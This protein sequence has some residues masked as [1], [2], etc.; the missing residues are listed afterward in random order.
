MLEIQNEDSHFFWTFDKKNAPPERWETLKQLY[1]AWLKKRYGSLDKA[2]SAWEAARISGDNPSDGRM[3]LLSAWHM[4]SGGLKSAPANRKRVSDQVRFLT[5]N[6]RSFYRKAIAYFRTECGYRGLISCGNW[7]TADASILGPLER[8]CYTAGDVIDHHGYFDHG[9]K[10]DGANWS[11]RP[12]HTFS[13]QSALN[14]RHANP[15]PYVE[16]GGHPNIISEI[17][18]PMPNMYRA[19][20]P[21]LT[22][23]YGSLNGLDGIC[24]FSIGSASWD[25]GISKFPMSNPVVLGSFFATSLL[26]RSNYVQEAPSVVTENVA[27]ED[28]FAL[29][30]SN[31]FVRPALDQLRADQIP[32]SQTGRIEEAID[33]ATFYV[34]RVIRSFHGRPEDSLIADTT[35]LIDRENKTIRSV[36]GELELDYD[37]EVATMNATKAQGAAG[38]L[39]G[40]GSIHLDNIDIKMMNDYGTVLVAALDDKPLAVSKKILIQCMTVDQLYGWE[41]SEP[42]GMGGTIRNVGSAPWGMQKIKASVTLRLKGGEPEKVI[43]CDENGYSTSK[44][45][46]VSGTVSAFTVRINETAPYTVLLR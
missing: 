3:E 12:G 9:H 17:G 24:H 22:A 4:T 1:G 29:K 16:I 7:R 31:V 14:L 19:E 37:K 21:F 41:T 34:G 44:E 15:L 18:W 38:F 45:T 35:G 43:A 39:S 26:Y 23:A 27:V 6:M 10:G 42:G 8:Y 13:S 2:I 40:K 25:Q 36:T 33:P 28:L 30:G 32:S 5:E 20:W 46:A 11:V